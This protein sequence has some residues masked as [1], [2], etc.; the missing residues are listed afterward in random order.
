MRVSC[1]PLPYIFHLVYRARLLGLPSSC[2]SLNLCAPTPS[3]KSFQ[4]SLWERGRPKPFRLSSRNS[5][6]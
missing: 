3:C 5:G 4:N 6:I 1:D 2:R